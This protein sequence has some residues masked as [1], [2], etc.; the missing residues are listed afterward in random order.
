VG[1]QEASMSAG[2]KDTTSAKGPSSDLPLRASKKDAV[3]DLVSSL[4]A[5]CKEESNNSSNKTFEGGTKTTSDSPKLTPQQISML[6]SMP[7]IQQFLAQ[8]MPDKLPS[9]P[10]E[11]L[12]EEEGASKG[13]ESNNSEPGEPL[14]AAVKNKRGKTESAN[15]ALKGVALEPDPKIEPVPHTVAITK[16][17]CSSN[18][19]EDKVIL[20]KS[21]VTP[22]QE[23]PP[24]PKGTSNCKIDGTAD[25]PVP[26]HS[27]QMKEGG[28]TSLPKEAKSLHSSTINCGGRSSSIG[29]ERNHV[30][31]DGRQE[32]PLLQ[33]DNDGGAE[34]IRSHKT[35]T[36]SCLLPTAP[37]TTNNKKQQPNAVHLKPPEKGKVQG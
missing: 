18:P 7:E 35:T 14:T 23:I 1:A 26:D 11:D 33:A 2:A 4:G 5:N 12:E 24:L 36:A 28:C 8:M 34:E 3:A 37:G 21:T 29:G 27:I 25:L 9:N 6:Q 15:K 19:V 13:C 22:E 20:D 16:P 31:D 32:Q 10:E 30:D 17:Q